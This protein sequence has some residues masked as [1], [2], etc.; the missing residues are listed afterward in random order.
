VSSGT[1][2]LIGDHLHNMRK[3]NNMHHGQV[4]S[5][6]GTIVG[7]A[8]HNMRRNARSDDDDK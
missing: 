4:S 2:T 3:N 1:G 5:G 7:D 8:L 6:T